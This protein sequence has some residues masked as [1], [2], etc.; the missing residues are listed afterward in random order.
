MI[1]KGCRFRAICLVDDELPHVINSRLFRCTSCDAYW[2]V[3]G[4]LQVSLTFVFLS[5][6]YTVCNAV[7]ACADHHL[8]TCPTCDK[9]EEHY[10]A[11]YSSERKLHIMVRDREVYRMVKEGTQSATV[12]HEVWKPGRGWHDPFHVF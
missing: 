5:S 8:R 2:Y 6:L 3:R 11:D 4:D 1:C 9:N 10:V 7:H 12:P